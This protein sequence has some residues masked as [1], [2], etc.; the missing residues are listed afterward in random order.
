MPGQ[1]NVVLTKEIIVL[2]PGPKATFGPFYVLWALHSKI[3]RDQWNRVVFMQTNREDVGSRWLEIEIP[4]PKG[5]S[6][7]DAV[8]K[9][10]ND[11]FMAI[12]AARTKLAGYLSESGQHHFFVSGAEP[13]SREALEEAAAEDLDED[14]TDPEDYAGA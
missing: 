13:P 12:A 7:A 5:R 1:E 9:P 11:Y 8:A 2:R 10:F 3:V 4:V 6:H 14:M